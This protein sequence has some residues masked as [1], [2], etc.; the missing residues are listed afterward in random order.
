MGDEIG[1]FRVKEWG[2]RLG[3]IGGE[4]ERSRMWRVSREL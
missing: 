3:W 2:E 4:R 1:S